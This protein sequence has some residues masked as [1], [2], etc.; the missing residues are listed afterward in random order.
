MKSLEESSMYGHDE[1][2]LGFSGVESRQSYDRPK[3]RTGCRQV[4]V[5]ASYDTVAEMT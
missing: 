1:P 4:T 2:I 3:L 5:G